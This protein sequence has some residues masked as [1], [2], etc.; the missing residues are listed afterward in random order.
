[1]RPLLLLL[2]PLTLCAQT[3][4]FEVASIRPLNG[5]PVAGGPICGA[6]LRP[7]NLVSG[8]ESVL[9]GGTA[10]LVSLINQAYVDSLEGFD[11][12][13]WARSG[14]RFAVSVR[15]PPN[16]TAATCREMLRNLLAERFHLVTAMESREVARY[17]VKVAKSGLK[18]K[19]VDAS[20]DA[21]SAVVNSQKDGIMHITF[22]GAPMS[23]IVSTIGVYA[24]IEARSTG[25][26]NDPAYRI[27]TGGGITDD[28]GLTGFYEGTFDVAAGPPQKDAFGSS[29]SDVLTEQMGL[30]L[31]LRRA[32]GKVLVIRSGDRM[33]TE[34]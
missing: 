24:I 13:E 23:R 30:A 32:P 31:E 7:E 3:P 11:F 2:L 9:A 16:T 21:A 15:I 12:P 26:V 25:L 29:L 34:N 8:P 5:P 17:Y 28:T 4:A 1:M 18:L 19:A 14:D 20:L 27:A 22:H 33:P 10:T 6:N